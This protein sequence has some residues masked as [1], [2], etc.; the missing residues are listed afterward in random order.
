MIALKFAYD[1]GLRLIELDVGC[2]ELLGL[3]HKGSPCYVP[4]GGLVDD[5]CHWNSCF[6]F[7]SFSVVRK[8]CNK[9]SFPSFGYRGFVLKF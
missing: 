9:L 3:I 2:P 7:L 6:Q 1:I 8:D 4:I 5:I